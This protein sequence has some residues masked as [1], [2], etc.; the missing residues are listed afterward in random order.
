MKRELLSL[1]FGILV[2]VV[3]LVGCAIVGLIA[4][5]ITV[6][7]GGE[8]VAMP[9]LPLSGGAIVAFLAFLLFGAWSLGDQILHPRS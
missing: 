6:A 5:T 4:N 8:A 3:V 7:L 9:L 2:V 1:L